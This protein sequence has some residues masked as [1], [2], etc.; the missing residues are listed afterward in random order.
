[1]K[2]WIKSSKQDTKPVK[3]V[4]EITYKDDSIAASDS[5]P[6]KHPSIRK[7]RKKSDLWLREINNLVG[8][9]LGTMKGK[10]F[11]I[12]KAYQSGKSY[13]YYIRFNPADKDG[14]LFN[15][16]LVFQIELRDHTSLTHGDKYDSSQ[17]HLFMKAYYYDDKKY[18]N[19]F[20][21]LT[22]L[23]KLLDELQEGNFNA[24]FD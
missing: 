18:T 1:M 17:G 14:N 21:L 5:E 20:D 3:I 10:K 7:S 4:L 15:Q 22:D 24:F 13:A 16:E 8:S 23:Y 2:R 19:L 11:N 6:L 9:L 12:I